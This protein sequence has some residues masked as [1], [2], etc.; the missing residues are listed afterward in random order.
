MEP[1]YESVVLFL[2]IF[3][4]DVKPEGFFFGSE[5]DSI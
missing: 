1:N 4:F 2:V 3:A 5:S